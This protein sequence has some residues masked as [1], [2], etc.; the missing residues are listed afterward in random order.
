[1][2]IFPPHHRRFFFFFFLLYVNYVTSSPLPATRSRRSLHQPFF[3]ANSSNPSPPPATPI[4]SSPSSSSS[5][6][7]GGSQ[8]FPVNPTPT[9]TTNRPPAA[10]PSVTIPANL[11]GLAW[12][13]LARDGSSDAKKV[14][15]AVVI[16]LI[17]LA[18]LLTVIFFF[19]R[20]NSG[21]FSWKATRSTSIRLFSVGGPGSVASKDG[22]ASGSDVLYLGTLVDS[23]RPQ[24]EDSPV[25][26]PHNR[27]LSSPASFHQ[28]S[29]DLHPLPP[30]SRPCWPSEDGGESTDDGDNESFYSPRA[31]SS[32]NHHESSDAGADSQR[33]FLMH[34]T[35][36]HEFGGSIAT[37]PSY[38]SS[39][40][41]S[42]VALKAPSPELDTESSASD[43]PTHDS[44]RLPPPSSPM[45]LG[46]R[47]ILPSPPSSPSE[48][49][50]ASDKST[51]SGNQSLSG[52]PAP[53]KQ[54][55]FPM[56]L[57]PPP[58][59]PPPKGSLCQFSVPPLPPSRPI[60]RPPP[61]IT[62]KRNSQYMKSESSPE[63]KSQGK[64]ISPKNNEP[65]AE[66]SLDNP[67][68]KLKPLHWDKV[69]ASS[70][71]V[72]VWDQ[73]K[74]S[75]FQLNEEMIETLFVCNPTNAAPKEPHRRAV[76][77]SP[78][79]EK[80][81][82]DP[83]KSQ[84]LAILLRA[85]NV[86]KEEICNALSEGNTDGLGAEL[87]ETLLKMAPT[88]EEEL[89]LKGQTEDGNSKLGTA[90]RFLKAVLDIPYA[91]KRADAMLYMANFESEVSYLRK[92]FRTL[93]AA[94]EELKSSRLFL[95]LLE[96]VLKTGN[97]M[98]VGTNRGD[99]QAFNLDTLL[100]LVDVKGTDGKTTLLHFVVQEI[101]R[102][103]EAHLA[104][105]RSPSA[106]LSPAGNHRKLGLQVVAALSG[107]LSNVKKAASM[108]SDILGSSVRKLAA[109]LEKVS[110]ALRLSGDDEANAHFASSMSSF[111]SKA[112]EEIAQ[113]RAE[114]N[115]ALSL[116]K[117]IT[118]YFH[119]NAAREE[120][121]PFRIF[122]IVSDFLDV[123]D[124]VCKQVGKM[125]QQTAAASAGRQLP[126]PANPL[127]APTARVFR[128]RWTDS[129]E[130]SGSSSS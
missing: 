46:Q 95:K 32:G 123:L 13:T 67:R 120:A 89:K 17:A 55:I 130:D 58:P 26:S 12:P 105:L 56:K 117:E 29:P 40:S 44:F 3:L 116:V 20:R 97:R 47:N 115:A 124:R 78:V 88:K 28:R 63:A 60:F 15:V 66:N 59:P 93:E 129:D 39:Q 106:E 6:G 121:H 77:T 126:V 49:S 68:P 113:I 128:R 107:E 41:T 38:P 114:E 24:G 45:T 86:T 11:S 43:G 94:C 50:T 101:I 79:Q 23:H 92:S 8:F 33:V 10:I 72:M 80:R 22:V 52:Q 4:T 19:R 96:A 109:G 53:P 48:K 118:E 16:S 30:L 108:D 75:S 64:L 18:A 54:T 36:R 102:S 90:E 2:S 127:P 71:R 82:L 69:W 83:K 34:S 74:S 122:V 81:V 119:G 100:K 104:N 21:E 70:D 85:L 111:K 51:V 84:N 14:I 37:T 57:P 112:E 65:P 91:F 25:L 103:E 7:G 99:A 31:S 5:G 98:N 73:L 9:A 125:Q 42:P 62:P 110:D 61:L 1:M 76:L 87:L 35:T 27:K